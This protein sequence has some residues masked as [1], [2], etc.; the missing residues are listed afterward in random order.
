[1][2]S[3]HVKHRLSSIAATR[4]LY[5]MNQSLRIHI[6]VLFVHNYTTEINIGSRVQ[7]VTNTKLGV[8]IKFNVIFSNNAYRIKHG[9]LR[10]YEL[11]V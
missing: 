7:N 4:S 9:Y 5:Q 6:H 3:C 11:L 8:K 1:M 10:K 2:M